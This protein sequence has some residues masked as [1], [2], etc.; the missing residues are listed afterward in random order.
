MRHFEPQTDRVRVR[1][2]HDQTVSATPE[3]IFP[4][5]CP[6]REHD[7]IPGWQC[8]LV[9]TAS[10]AA[11]PGCVFQTDRPADGGLDTWVVSRHEPPARVA[12]VR[13]NA[14]RTIHY[15]VRLASLPDGATRL[16]WEQEITALSP[17]GDRHVAALREQDFVA[18]IEALE[19]MLEHYLRTGEPL[20]VAH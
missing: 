16:R 14:L 7:W 8:R 12:F 18:T 20:A 4:L 19:A 13:V 5:L 3:A 2:A 6:V 1:F 11:E 17:D 9:Y 10:G 15:D